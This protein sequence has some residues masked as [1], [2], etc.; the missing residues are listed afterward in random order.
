M[1]KIWLYRYPCGSVGY[2]IG[3]DRVAINRHKKL[4]KRFKYVMYNC[5]RYTIG[6]WINE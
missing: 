4:D 1:P 5:Y 2:F 3:I 6:G